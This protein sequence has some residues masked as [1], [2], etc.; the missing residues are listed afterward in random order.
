MISLNPHYNQSY[1]KQ[2]IAKI[3]NTVKLCVENDDYQLSLNKNRQENINFINDYSITSDRQKD[4]LLNLKVEDFCHSLKNTHPGYEHEIL[5]VFAPI[6]VLPNFF[7]EIENVQIYIKVNIM[8]RR[9][10]KFVAVISFHKAN[11]QITYC[12]KQ[13]D[14]EDA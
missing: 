14:K 2:D 13:S 1:T 7:G 4:I 5:Y 10:G 12:F 8:K 3:L 6:K 9:N 11:K